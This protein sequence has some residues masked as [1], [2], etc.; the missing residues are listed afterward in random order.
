MV[1]GIF[2]FG[3]VKRMVALAR[4][5][6][7]RHGIGAIFAVNG[8]PDALT[9]VR[10][11]G[12]ECQ[13]LTS[14]SHLEELIGRLKPQMLILDRREGPSRAELDALSRSI[15]VTA[16]IDDGS[17]RRLAADFAYIRRCRKY[18]ISIGPALA[19]FRALAGNGHCWA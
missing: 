3:H 18:K 13:L 19:P 9:P 5:L 10:R 17:E 11:A 15:P 4:A 2:G 16:V 1:A 12:F 14:Q 7:D 6:R 8:T